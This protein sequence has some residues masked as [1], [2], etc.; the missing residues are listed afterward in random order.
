MDRADTRM[1]RAEA[2]A[3]RM[4]ARFDKRMQGFGK[5]VKIGM[6]EL[7]DLRRLNRQIGERLDRFVEETGQN[8]NALIDSQQRT[9]AS[10]RAFLDSRKGRNG[11]N[12]GRAK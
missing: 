8:I 1:D 3:D 7:S 10:L 12:G 4:E 2:R 6:R 11:H 5:L 9:D